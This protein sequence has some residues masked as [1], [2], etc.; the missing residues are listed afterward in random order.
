MTAKESVTSCLTCLQNWSERGCMTFYLTCTHTAALSSLWTEMWKQT[1]KSLRTNK[2]WRNRKKES[3]VYC[4]RAWV[5]GCDYLCEC[6]GGGG[7]DMRSLSGDSWPAVLYSTLWR[8]WWQLFLHMNR[9]REGFQP[10]S[11]KAKNWLADFYSTLCT[12]SPYFL[13]EGSLKVQCAGLKG[14]YLYNM[15]DVKFNIKCVFISV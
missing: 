6:L 4:I 3:T 7:W 1:E 13:S 14:I 15:A 8:R 9:M 5:G 12:L 11:L 2:H 10:W